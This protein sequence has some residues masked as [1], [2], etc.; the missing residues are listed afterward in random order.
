MILATAG[1]AH[2]LKA[3]GG[4]PGASFIAPGRSV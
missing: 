3:S 4:T 2:R 1:G